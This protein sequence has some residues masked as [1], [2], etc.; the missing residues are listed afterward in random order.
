MTDQIV[1][2]VVDA[3]TS[4]IVIDGVDDA[5]PTITNGGVI[6]FTFTGES[7]PPGPQ[8][9]A[10]NAGP[11]AGV[12]DVALSGVADGDVLRYQSNTWRNF[13]ET[14]LTLDGGNF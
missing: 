11:L 8:G 1:I 14:D 10:G 7:G 13:K 12:T 2:T 5:M 9:P 4:P 3:G 6:E